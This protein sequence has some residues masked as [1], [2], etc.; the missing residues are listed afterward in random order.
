MTDDLCAEM[1]KLATKLAKDASDATD[2]KDRVDA[3]KA[4]TTYLAFRMKHPDDP[5]DEENNFNFEQGV[6]GNGTTVPS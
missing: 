5:S 3:F 4:L 2:L 1:D 6:H